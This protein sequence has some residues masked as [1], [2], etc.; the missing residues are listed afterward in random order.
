MFLPRVNI[1][2]SG[3]WDGAPYAE[4]VMS[5]KQDPMKVRKESSLSL[6]F[7]GCDAPPIEVLLSECD[8]GP[9]ISVVNIEPEK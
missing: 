2:P 1:P 8:S 3:H 4:M 5:A 7:R 6:A 9:I